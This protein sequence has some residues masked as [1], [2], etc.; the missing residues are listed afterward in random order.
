MPLNALEVQITRA[1]NNFEIQVPIMKKVLAYVTG[2]ST[3]TV[4]SEPDRPPGGAEG[5]EA[6]TFPQCQPW[7]PDDDDVD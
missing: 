5:V 2:G 3:S 7:H 4:A 6:D 1:A